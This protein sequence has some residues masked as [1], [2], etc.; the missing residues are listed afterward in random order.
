MIGRKFFAIHRISGLIAGLLL[1]AISLSGSVLVF[2]EEIDRQLNPALLTVIPEKEHASLDIIYKKAASIF[3]GSYIRFRRLP[4]QTDHAIELSIEQG[5]NWTF[6]YFN[7][8]NGKYL[9]SRDARNYFLGW[10]LGLHYSLL[11][12]KAGEFVV[13]VLSL[14]LILSVLT[15]S[16]VYR[17]HIFNVLTFKVS[18]H[19]KNRRKFLSSLHRVVGVWTLI[20]NLLFA[21]TGFWMM[22]S[23]FLP[24]S[25]FHASVTT[26]SQQAF[27]LSLDTLRSS[28]EKANKGFKVTSI[29]LPNTSQNNFTVLGHIQG[30]NKLYNEFVN[31]I[32]Y[33]G[34]TGKE[35]SRAFISEQS[36]RNKWDMMVLPLHSGS[37]G[38]V[39]IKIIYC[40]FGL[41]PALLSVTGFFLWLKRRKIIKLK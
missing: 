9:A 21:I 36:F 31:S 12:G 23:V 19:L 15:G 17:K 32:E 7:P 13:G 8:Y 3:P 26:R 18:L 41:S 35:L 20:F 30:Q 10:V 34:S 27:R 2:S 5:E 40:I 16:Y 11:A 39:F 14:T 24:E 28:V 33:D 22:K 38:N 25:Y 1:L 4:I 37:Y 29:F 6:A